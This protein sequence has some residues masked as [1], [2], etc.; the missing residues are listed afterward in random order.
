M[1]KGR[2]LA[3][4][5]SQ[6][7]DFVTR[8]LL[9]G[10]LKELKSKGLK[11]SDLTIVWVPGAFEIPLVALTLAKKKSIQ[12]VI[13][14]GAVIRGETL[15]FELVARGTAQGIT[16]AALM[17]GKPILFGVLSTDTI[18]QAYKR[19]EAKGDNKGKDAAQAALS[20]IDLLKKF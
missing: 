16:Q 1:T 6:F 5:V 7:N 11:D 2:K 12:A 3:I 20:M 17:T 13:C 15:H 14:L 9:N 19:S 18:D 4:V 8:R 10:C